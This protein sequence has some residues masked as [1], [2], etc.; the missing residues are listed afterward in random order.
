MRTQRKC[1]IC[2][3]LFASSK[4]ASFPA[5][6]QRSGRLLA[7][8]NPASRFAKRRRAIA[9]SVTQTPP[10]PRQNHTVQNAGSTSPF[11]GSCGGALLAL[12]PI[13]T[14]QKIIAVRHLRAG[15]RLIPVQFSRNDGG[16][17]AGRAV[18]GAQDTPILDGPDP[19]AVLA[20]LRDVMEGLLMA[21]QT[22]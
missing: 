7:S 3:K 16:S 1:H 10:G 8:R 11:P 21:R 13:V 2:H 18:L 22:C 9:R 14:R 4:R 5:G 17:V 19:E 15:G 12:H 20:L 6:G